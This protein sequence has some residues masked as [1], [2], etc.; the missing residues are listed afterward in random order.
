MNLDGAGS[1][2][3]GSLIHSQKWLHSSCFA[4]SVQ[5]LLDGTQWLC[6]RG[7]WRARG[8]RG[9]GQPGPSVCAVLHNVCNNSVNAHS[10]V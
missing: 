5:A 8:M 6:R 3:K 2:C 7:S 4:V 1:M 9:S 10:S